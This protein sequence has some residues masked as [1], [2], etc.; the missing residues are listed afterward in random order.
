MKLLSWSGLSIL[1]WLVALHSL[2]VGFG[3]ILVPPDTM[4]HFGYSPYQE[5]FFS[6]QAGVFHFVLVVAYCL[7]AA[8]P[9]RSEG[10]LILSITAKFIATAFL[11][12]YFLFVD[13][14][15]VVLFSGIADFTMGL[16]ILWFWLACRRKA[17]PPAVG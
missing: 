6:V 1:L 3:L 10:L 13:G 16:A 7:A 14:I 9:R 2:A 17:D 5:R 11:F 8:M 4:Q 15:W 12:I